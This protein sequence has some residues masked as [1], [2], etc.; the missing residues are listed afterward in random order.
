MTLRVSP[1]RIVNSRLGRSPTLRHDLESQ[2]TVNGPAS[3]SYRV[4]ACLNMRTAYPEY[5][6]VSQ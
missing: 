2:T 6:N 1:R 4:C 3:E 5:H